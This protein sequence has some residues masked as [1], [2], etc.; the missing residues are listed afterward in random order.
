MSDIDCS[1]EQRLEVEALESIWVGEFE[2][3]TEEPFTY[4]V[5]IKADR[6]DEASN[7]VV[8]KMKVEYPLDYPKVIPKVQFKNLS[9]KNLTISDFNNCSKIFRDTAEELIGEQMIFEC[10]ENIRN[11]LQSINDVFVQKR[12]Q[13]LEEE[14]IREE[15][16]GKKFIAEQRLDYTP[17]N[18]VTFGSWLEK[19]MAERAAQKEEEM[20]NR[21]K[22][23]LERDSRK[24]GKAYFKDKQGLVGSNIAFEEDEIDKLI[25]EGD[26]EEFKEEEKVY[27]DE[28]L[29]DE[30]DL[31]DVDLD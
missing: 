13:E 19:F 26:D 3:I 18:A 11:F 2:L 29:F 23:E 14:K 20:K 17:V 21:T 5:E 10:I 15:N 27:Y 25:E 8:I 16:L 31:D 9:P 22:D 7:Y 1:E 30:E 24:T 6:E 4:E 28:D 12:V